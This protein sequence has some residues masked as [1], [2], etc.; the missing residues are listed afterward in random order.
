[1]SFCSNPKGSEER[2]E[3]SGAEAEIDNRE[4]PDLCGGPRHKTL[5]SRRTRN[6]AQIFDVVGGYGKDGSVGS[7]GKL[8]GR[9]TT[10][11]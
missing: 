2:N 3:F 6:P 11:T 5:A 1:M 9:E 4:I 7:C 8:D 10:Y